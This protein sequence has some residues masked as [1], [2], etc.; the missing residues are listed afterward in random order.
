MNTKY[1]N[2]IFKHF[3]EMDNTSLFKKTVQPCYAEIHLPGVAEPKIFVQ[4]TYKLK[5]KWI[6]PSYGALK[7]GIRE[8]V[9]AI[10]WSSDDRYSMKKQDID[11]ILNEMYET[12]II[13][14]KDYVK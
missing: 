6:Y 1:Q 4:N 13:V 9:T 8:Y 2:L 14:I 10:I 3:A 5:D 11:D 12:G 7:R